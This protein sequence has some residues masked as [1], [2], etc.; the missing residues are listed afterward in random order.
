MA[1]K[2]SLHV[3]PKGIRA[4]IQEDESDSEAYVTQ[5]EIDD[6]ISRLSEKKEEM[7]GAARPSISFL[8]LD[9]RSQIKEQGFAMS[10]AC[11]Q[12]SV[13]SITSSILAYFTEVIVVIFLTKQE[14]QVLTLSYMFNLTMGVGVIRGL[15]GAIEVLVAMA[16]GASMRKKICSMYY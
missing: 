10:N 13:L 2:S 9:S 3:A 16:L 5:S 7:I 11:I 1:F 4:A 6:K 15:N 8:D 12:S 14:R